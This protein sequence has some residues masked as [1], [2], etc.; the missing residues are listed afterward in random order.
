MALSLGDYHKIDPSDFEKTGALDPILGIDTRLFIDPSLLRHTDV[1]EL[2]ESYERLSFHFS[3]AIRIIRHIKSEGDAFWKQ[4]DKLLQF[5]EVQG[6]CIGYSS[7]DSPGKGAGPTKRKRLLKTIS[8]L[9]QAG[10][11]DAA[12]FEL[13]G[14]FEDGIGPDLISDMIAKIIMANLVAF[15]QRVCSDLG[16]PMET[17]SYSRDLPPEDLPSNPFTGKPIILVPKQILR[18]LPVAETFA[19]IFWITKH[20]EAIRKELNKIVSD[21]LRNL[22][23][24]EQK[25]KVKESFIKYPDLLRQVIA[26]YESSGASFYDFNDDPAGETIWYRASR[27][28]PKEAELKLSL[29][30]KPT[31]DEVYEVVKEICHHFKRLLEDNQLSRLL[32]DKHG[33]PKHE[34]A[35]QLLFFGIASAYCEANDLDLSPESDGGR[36][37][38]DFKVSSGFR[39]KVLVEIKLTSNKQLQ[40]G[41]EKQ[42][43]IYQAAERAQK[44]IYLVVHNEGITDRRWQ[45]FSD[46]IKYSGSNAPEVIVAYA[47]PK[48]SASKADE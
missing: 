39:G 1:P 46:L 35:A 25:H 21:S 3:N 17:I 40:H 27:D 7:K 13:V 15:T 4:A 8:Q 42:L 5:P 45:E 6:L 47:A 33:K 43:P 24:S 41:F 38:V 30:S 16:L 10:N 34:S 36:G 29:S 12:I 22:S 28:L 23:P 11:E 26:A 20:N 18:D 44:G 32:Y 19:D 37:P 48:L 2:K 31:L 14:A 9:V